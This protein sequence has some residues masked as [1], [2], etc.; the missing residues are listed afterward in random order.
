MVLADGDDA[1]LDLGF[2]GVW[3]G[4]RATLAIGEAGGA[5]LEVAGAPL[6]AGLA[7]DAIVGAEVGEVEEAFLEITDEVGALRHG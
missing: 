3:A 6:V 4:L 2:R 7:A 1:G 5:F